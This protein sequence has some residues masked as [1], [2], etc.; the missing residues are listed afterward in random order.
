MNAEVEEE[1]VVLLDRLD[2]ITTMY[3]LEIG[4]D[5]T[6]VITNN[7]KAF[8]KDQDKRSDRSSGELTWDQSSLM[9]YQNPRFF[10]RTAQTPA[11]LL[12]LNWRSY[13][14]TR[15]SHLLLRLSW[16]ER[17]SYPPSFMPVRAWHWQQNS[18]Q[19]SSPLRWDALGDFR[20]IWWTRRFEAESVMQLECM[21][22][23]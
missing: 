9:K 4:P 13:G 10:S 19:R 12:F 11:A 3:K 20:T 17:L 6:K 8:Q 16:C 22:I 23:S 14:R 5:K 1:A 15:T 2:T 7:P 21:M 18:K